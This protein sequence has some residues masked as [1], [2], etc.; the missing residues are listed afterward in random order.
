MV[1]A[2]TLLFILFLLELFNINSLHKVSPLNIYLITMNGLVVFI[3]LVDRYVALKRTKRKFET[4]SH[5]GIRN[6][7]LTFLAILLFLGGRY[8]RFLF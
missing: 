5:V 7:V 8:P 4:N 1:F 3:A 6:T 2:P